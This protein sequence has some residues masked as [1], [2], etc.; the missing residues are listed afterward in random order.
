MARAPHEN[1]LIDTVAH[2]A[3]ASSKC[4]T[5]MRDNRKMIS[6]CQSGQVRAGQPRG[7][8][9][10]VGHAWGGSAM[11]ERVVAY[12]GLD[13]STLRA[14][15][16][17]GSSERDEVAA[18][19]WIHPVLRGPTPLSEPRVCV[20]RAQTC[21]IQF[22]SSSVSRRHL[23]I[24]RQG[25]SFAVR[26]LGS[27]NGTYLNG[28][29]VQHGALSRGDVLRVGEYVG[30]VG[31]TPTRTD[32]VEFSALAPGHMGSGTLAMQLEMVRRA[33]SGGLRLILTGETGV[34]K[35]GAMPAPSAIATPDRRKHDLQM[36]AV[37]LKRTRRNVKAAAETLAFTRQRA[38]R[39]TSGRS[40]AEV[41]ALETAPNSAQETG[42]A[43]APACRKTGDSN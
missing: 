6:S 9:S 37:A 36:L 28:Q 21:E 26:D 1:S 24:Y 39:L 32:H 3:L 15:G 11:H 19:Q 30:I 38:Y 17:R 23:E 16:M 22:E 34:G 33:A 18:I 2:R 14:P 42:E 29:R 10:P 12:L 41:M 43:P 13:D 4:R 40:A 8:S 35:S 20:G 5:S 31:I 25:P 7:P 27:T